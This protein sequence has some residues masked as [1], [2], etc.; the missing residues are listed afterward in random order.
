MNKEE[1]LKDIGA[2]DNHRVL[3]WMA[4]ERTKDSH[5]PV[6]EFGAGD[7]STPYLRKYCSEN[8]REFI[9]LESVA[10]W[11]EKCESLHIPNWVTAD[12]YKNYSVC[13]IDHSPGEHRHEALAILKD[14]VDILVVHDSEAAA[15]GYM[16]D[17]IWYLFKYRVNCR[18]IIGEGAEASA[19]SNTIDITKFADNPG[20][21]GGFKIEV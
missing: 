18:S 19:L 1:F 13:L 9:S 10:Q 3:L 2:W 7:G 11:A 6:C 15:T 21:N 17:K 12:V 4:L 20:Y 14:K 5:L 8:N 16:L